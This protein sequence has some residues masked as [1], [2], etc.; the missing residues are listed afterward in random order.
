MLSQRERIF[1]GFRALRK[2]GRPVVW[3]SVLIH[4]I[5]EPQGTSPGQFACKNRG[6]RLATHKNSDNQT[7]SQAE[8]GRS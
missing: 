6:Q 2:N 3:E 8:I 7:D 4:E 1:I 5:C